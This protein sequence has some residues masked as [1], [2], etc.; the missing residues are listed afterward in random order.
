MFGRLPLIANGLL[1][2]LHPCVCLS[3]DE[4]PVLKDKCSVSLLMFDIGT[5]PH[6]FRYTLV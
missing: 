1:R 3:A 4:A 5:H 6:H 2:L